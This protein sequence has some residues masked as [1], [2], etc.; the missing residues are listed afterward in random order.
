MSTRE[1]SEKRGAVGAVG[2][3]FGTL[4][5]PDILYFLAQTVHINLFTLEYQRGKE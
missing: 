5:Y 2:P 1:T 4:Y 3:V